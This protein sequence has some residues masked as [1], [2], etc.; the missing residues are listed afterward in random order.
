MPKLLAYAVASLVVFTALT[1]SAQTAPRSSRQV[2]MEKDLADFPGREAV[3]YQVTYPPGTSNPPHR[4]DGHVF[5]HLLEGEV[6]V[7]VK[8]GELVTLAPGQTYYEA[9]TDVHIVSRNPSATVPARAMVFMIHMKGAPMT[10][11]VPE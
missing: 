10:R 2:F 11:P 5:L 3:V 1:I 9:P 8:G 7:Q 4:H 6:Q